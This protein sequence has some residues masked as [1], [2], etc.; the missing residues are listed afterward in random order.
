MGT[1]ICHTDADAKADTNGI[2]TETNMAPTSLVI[3]TRS[4]DFCA[5]QIDL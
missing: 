3:N 5:D 2:R 1:R 4:A